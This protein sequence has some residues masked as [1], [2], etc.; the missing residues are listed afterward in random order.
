MIILETENEENKPMHPA[1]KFFLTFLIMGF[2]LGILMFGCA[3]IGAYYSCEG[4]GE[5]VG[6]KCKNPDI[7]GVCEFGNQLYT[8]EQINNT[9]MG[10]QI[11]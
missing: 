11:K 10:G 4:S 5:L 3:Y 8:Y 9:I 1:L 6:F 7:I 2:A